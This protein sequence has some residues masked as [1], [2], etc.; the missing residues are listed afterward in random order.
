MAGI[1]VSGPGPY[2]QRT[3]RQP[4]QSVPNAGY[5]EQK[6]YKQLQQDA[7]MAQSGGAAAAPMDFATLFGSA[8]DRVIPMDA[9]SNQPG[10]PV[11]SGASM[12]A[13]VGIEALNL[14]DD[15]SKR[16]LQNLA[17]QL[18]FLEWMANRPDASWGLRQLVRRVKSSL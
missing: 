3:D 10:T 11:T 16:D 8:A 15:K 17:P 5:G 2:S 14:G 12:G 18:P 6:A 7:P 1:P 13:G 4:I 9:E